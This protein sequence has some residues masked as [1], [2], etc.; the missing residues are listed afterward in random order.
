VLKETNADGLRQLRKLSSVSLADPREELRDIEALLIRALGL[1]PNLNRTRFANAT[2]WT[3]VRRLEAS[4]FL[5]K[6][7]G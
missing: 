3:Q 2:E 5:E 6:I 1:V 4:I 7:R